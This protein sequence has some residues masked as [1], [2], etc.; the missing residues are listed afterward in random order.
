MKSEQYL[1]F[2]AEQY[3]YFS[4]LLKEELIKQMVKP[5]MN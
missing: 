3:F 2:S 1:N 5:K 4:M